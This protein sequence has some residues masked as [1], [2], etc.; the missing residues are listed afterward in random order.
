V[1]QRVPVKL[2]FDEP[3]ENLEQLWAGESVEPRVN[4][5]SNQ[6]H[7]ERRALPLEEALLGTLNDHAV[8]DRQ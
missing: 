6:P 2:V 4:V 5:R 3:A 1:V 8:S 7:R